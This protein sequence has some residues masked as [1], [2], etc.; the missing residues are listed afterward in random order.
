MTHYFPSSVFI[1]KSYLKPPRS[2]WLTAEFGE[3]GQDS[4]GQ[5]YQEIPELCSLGDRRTPWK[6]SVR[7]SFLGSISAEKYVVP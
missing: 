7:T 4:G 3:E 1:D 5:W 2:L 6:S